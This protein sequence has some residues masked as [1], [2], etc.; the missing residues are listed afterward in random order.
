MLL[1]I[2][3]GLVGAI[4]LRELNRITAVCLIPVVWRELKHK[5]RR[6]FKCLPADPEPIDNQNFE[7]ET[8]KNPN[9]QTEISQ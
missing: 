5:L 1:Y 3:N 4:C 2:R 9:F 6:I 7:N 8:Q